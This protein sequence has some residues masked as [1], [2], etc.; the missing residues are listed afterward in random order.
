MYVYNLAHKWLGAKPQGQPTSALS[1]A[2]NECLILGQSICA[3]VIIILLLVWPQNNSLQQQQQQ[4]NNNNILQ[5]RVT[6]SI[7]HGTIGCLS[8]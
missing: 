7:D 1:L 6:S 8:E 5:Q 4:N 3:N 2:R